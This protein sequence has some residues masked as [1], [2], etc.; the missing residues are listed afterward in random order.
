MVM[1]KKL[2]LL[3]CSFSKVNFILG[4][5]LLKSSSNLCVCFVVFVHHK[6]VVHIP[7]LTLNFVLY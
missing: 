4:T 1:S 7:K 3:F 2:I 5:K 6:N